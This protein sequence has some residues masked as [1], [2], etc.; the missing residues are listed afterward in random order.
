MFKRKS[1]KVTLAWICIIIL[2]LPY[3]SNV[4]ATEK[5]SEGITNFLGSAQILST[6]KTAKLEAIY[7]RRGEVGFNFNANNKSVLKI[8]DATDLNNENL[9][10]FYCLDPDKSFPEGE[11][12]AMDYT[13]MGK[14]T[15]LSIEYINNYKQELGEEKYNELLWIANN[16]LFLDA[17]DE[18]IIEF[19]KTV[20]ED[21]IKYQYSNNV[22]LVFE[23]KSYE[24]ES[25]SEEEYTNIYANCIKEILDTYC[26]P[27]L[28]NMVQQCAIWYITKADNKYFKDISVE[29]GKAT[30]SEV[31]YEPKNTTT[32]DTAYQLPAI[33]VDLIFEG[34]SIS[35]NA[36]A[37]Q[38]V[39]II[40]SYILVGAK[41][42]NTTSIETKYP[43]IDRNV[44]PV[45]KVAGNSDEYYIVGPFKINSNGADKKQYE[46]KLSVSDY[47]IYA[48][49]NCETKLKVSNLNEL[50]DTQ[51]YLRIS[52]KKNISEVKLTLTFKEAKNRIPTIW[53]PADK[54]YQRV[55]LVNEEITSKDPESISVSLEQGD[56]ALR[57]YL[58]KRISKDE[59]I[60]INRNVNVDTSTISSTQ[61]ATYKHSKNAI[62]VESGDTLIY[63]ISVYNEGNIDAIAQEITDYLP[64]GLTFVKNSEINN[65]YGWTISADGKIAKTTYLAN[66]EL[67][68]YGNELDS[69]YIQIECKV[70][71]GLDSESILTNVAE[72][73]KDNIKDRDS[74]TGSIDNSN[75]DSTFSGDKTNKDDLSDEN[76]YYKGLQDDD[77]FEKVII[78]GY[79]FDF[80]LMKFITKINGEKL[81]TSREP[82][83]DTTPLKNGTDT[84]A[85]YTKNTSSNTVQAGD[86]V[87]YKIRIYNESS[88]SGY[89]EEVA[90]ILPEGLGFLVKYNDNIDNYWSISEAVKNGAKTIKLSEIPDGTKNLKLDDFTGETKLED[91]EVLVGKGAKLISTKLSSNKES[92]LIEKYDGQSSKLNYKDVEVTCIVLNNELEDGQLT[93]I[94]EINKAV[95]ENKNEIEDRDSIPGTITDVDNYP[96]NDKNQDDHDYEFLTE[97]AK[98]FDLSLQKFISGLNDEKITNRVPVVTKN[99]DGT[100]KYN[101]TT[102]A[103]SVANTDLVTYT[104]RVYNEGEKDGYAAE[105][106][107]DIPEG[108]V[109]ETD[110]EINKKF[111]WKLYDK[112][113]KVTEDIN[114]AT[115]VKT[116]Y[117]SKEVSEKRNDDALIK[118]Y[119]GNANIPDYKDVQIVFKVDDTK[120]QTVQTTDQRII[121]NIAEIARD[122]DENGKDVDDID[123]EP[124]NGKNGEDDLDNEKIYVKIFDLAL[125]KTLTKIIVTEDGKTREILPESKESLLKVEVHRKKIDTTVVKFV[126]DITI[127]NEGEIAGFATEIKDHIPEG[128]KFVAEENKNWTKVSEN[129]I[130]TNALA[131]EEITPGQSKSVQVVLTWI[132]G[133]KNLGIKTN[134]AEISEDYNDKGDTP[135]IDSIVNNNKE[136]EDDIDEAPVVLSIATGSEIT[137]LP[138]AFAVITIFTTGLILIKKY[139]I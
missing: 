74:D 57:K 59:T 25:T 55:L 105:I 60:D 16:I 43:S 45:A 73:T 121:K 65:K 103:L 92:N 4:F 12:A 11:S 96:G 32:V 118:A 123:S 136:G 139:V 3:T 33:L 54:N 31:G 76:Y 15:D 48:D 89:A 117:L 26:T 68:A 10:N 120:L 39:D 50:V 104:I 135:D 40:F 52:S 138:I 79:T 34:R 66:R 77:D 127:K 37:K 111:G 102:E 62:E 51:F 24:A 35:V 113:G 23:G 81:K 80:N 22:P 85:K 124:A 46:V 64:N 13:N 72:I 7:P 70:A 88:I 129:E 122:T 41:N 137:Y 100:F 90:D 14:L 61:T 5:V 17:S 6:T 128:L 110:N 78:K 112:Y 99:S 8:I 21:L 63:Q 67:K 106:Q 101:H 95:D 42:G 29:T 134:V 82:V 93:N 107:D 2:L 94:A 131:K 36:T 71:D 19:I 27:E 91:V 114:Q 83:V 133:E 49:S 115:A 28:I 84:N 109:F 126:Y 38:Y 47:E 130:V 30:D 9:N 18:E 69:A 1:L 86:L 98:K 97:E 56:L 58:V 116:D 75:I 119:D 125:E 20:F 44:K 53:D 87:T 108:L 132:N